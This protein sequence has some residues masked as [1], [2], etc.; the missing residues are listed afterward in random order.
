[1]ITTQ[2]MACHTWALSGNPAAGEGVNNA[3]VSLLNEIG[4]R[5]EH[6][7]NLQGRT[8]AQIRK[9]TIEQ[10]R[11]LCEVRTQQLD[12]VVRTYALTK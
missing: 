1:M 10:I 6:G 12:H 9:E 2:E 11:G 4:E 5:Y 7:E 8:L 3:Y